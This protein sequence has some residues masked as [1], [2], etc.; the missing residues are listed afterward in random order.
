MHH[1]IKAV[2]QHR[3]YNRRN[4]RGSLIALK[5]KE[6]R[7]WLSANQVARFSPQTEFTE[8]TQFPWSEVSQ[9]IIPVKEY[10]EWSENLQFNP[11]TIATW[12]QFQSCSWISGVWHKF[13]NHSY[14]VFKTF[15]EQTWTPN[16]SFPYHTQRWTPA[17]PTAGETE[18]RENS[19]EIRADNYK[20]GVVTLGC[21]YIVLL[22]HN[23][24]L[25][26]CTL[27]KRMRVREI[28]KSFQAA[29][30]KAFPLPS[31]SVFIAYEFETP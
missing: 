30:S 4:W 12:C 15:R 7:K 27:N 26:P 21:A 22:L 11:S 17:L 24:G 18:A 1:Y 14:K 16:F 10:M 5:L 3:K 9:Q 19:T 29:F 20:F 8:T 25:Q 2:S 31:I 23:W 28:L 6:Q 13:S